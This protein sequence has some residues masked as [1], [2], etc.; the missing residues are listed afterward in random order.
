[1]A[2][3]RPV[4]VAAG[5]LAKGDDGTLAILDPPGCCGPLA[6]I[7]VRYR[8]RS[9]FAGDGRARGRDHE[10]DLAPSARII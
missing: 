9:S 3:A 7:E 8:R 6:R 1:M 4:Q 5:R 2:L 10:A